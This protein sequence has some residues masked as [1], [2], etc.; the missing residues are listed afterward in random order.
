MMLGLD[1]PIG[2]LLIDAVATTALATLVGLTI[3]VVALLLVLSLALL[4]ALLPFP[5]RNLRLH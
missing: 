5:R 3:R 1:I 2:K 4:L